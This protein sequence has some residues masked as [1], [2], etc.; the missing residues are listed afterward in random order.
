MV[1]LAGEQV[2]AAGAAVDEQSLPGGVPPLDLGAVGRPRAGAPASPSPSRPSG[3]PGCRR[4][5]RAGSRP[6]SRR[7]ATRGRSPIRR[8]GESPSASQRAIVRRAAVPHRALQHRQREPVDLE[9]DD[10]GASVTVAARPSAGRSA[11][12]PGACRCR[13]R[14]CRGRRRA[15][16]SPPRPRTR[17]RAPTRT[18]RSE[19][20]VGDA[21]GGEQ[22]QRVERRASST[23][24]VS[25]ISGRRS[26]ATSG[27]SDRVQERRSRRGGERAEEVVDRGAG[28]DPGG[29][30]QRS[31]DTS[32]ATTSWIGPSFGR[33]GLQPGALWACSLVVIAG[34]STAILARDRARASSEGGDEPG[35]APVFDPGGRAL[36]GLTW[37]GHSTVVIDLDGTRLVTDPVLG[38]RVWHLRREAAVELRVLDTLTGFS[39]RTPTSTISTAHRSACWTCR[40]RSSCRAASG[41]L[42]RGWGFTRVH[43]VV[44]GD[45]LE[46]GAL[47]LRVTHAEHE[48]SRWPLTPRSASLG[49]VAAGLD[50]RL[51]RRG[52]RPLRRHVRA[53]GPSTSP[54]CPSPAGAPAPG[55]P[56]RP[57]RAAEALRLLRPRIAVP[58]HWG[59]YGRRSGAP[60]MIGPP[61]SSSA[62]PPRWRQ[63][64]MS[65]AAIGETLALEGVR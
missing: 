27:G 62:R 61:G 49:Y 25:S 59:T 5:S 43:E 38:R 55:R 52:H 13:R 21:V 22:H 3:R 37:L 11:G 34:C 48:S 42:L 15:R 30:E 40:C 17:P 10:P 29:D 2:A 7:S 41:G 46:L 60:S 20:A 58:V 65:G 64:S 32:Q 33:L 31:G 23:K 6:G 51:L 24:P 28:H 26:A 19:V 39:F 44:A 14:S 63:R 36:N 9:E 35:R 45:E 47:A 54:H 4:S 50:E 18:S 53:S 8:A 16:R 1:G 12:S 57:A 56:P